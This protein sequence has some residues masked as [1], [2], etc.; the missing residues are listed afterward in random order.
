MTGIDQYTEKHKMTIIQ[1]ELQNVRDSAAISDYLNENIDQ[2]Y[3]ALL[4]SEQE[5]NDR[6]E[7]DNVYIKEVRILDNGDIEI[8]YEYEWSF[9]SGC[10]D[11]R[12]AGL[13][14]ETLYTRLVNG[15]IELTVIERFEPRTTVDEF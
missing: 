10:K 9:Y 3:P 13:V 12:D 4:F 8:D 15:V 2:L 1:L 7:I 14:T 5:K 11:I 6:V